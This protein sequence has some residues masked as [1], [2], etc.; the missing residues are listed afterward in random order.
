MSGNIQM[1][2]TT[3]G[4][5]LKGF[6]R[7]LAG[8]SMFLTTYT[9][10]GSRALL[11]FTPEAPGTI[12]PV[13]L[14]ENESLICQK[15]SFMFAQESISL[16]V[17]FR[18]KLGVGFFGGEGF[19]LQKLTGPGLAF[20]EIAGE[21]QTY[22]LAPGQTIKIDPGHLAM[23]EPSVSQNIERIRGVRN[24]L[25]GGEGIFLATLTGPGR[26]WLQTLPLSNLAAKLS[27]YINTSAS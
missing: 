9:C 8:E 24:M 7:S 12:L 25:F 27:R 6:A 2:T 26:V 1:E 19:I 17:H 13:E 15:D 5:L 3:K 21:V 16:E 18:R 10:Q 11:T 14:K 4:G 20:I 22:N 23:H